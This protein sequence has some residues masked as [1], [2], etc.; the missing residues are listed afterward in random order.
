[1]NDPW[2]YVPISSGGGGNTISPPPNTVNPAKSCAASSFIIA[3]DRYRSRTQRMNLNRIEFE[4][5]RSGAHYEQPA[6]C[7]PMPNRVSYIGF[8][9]SINHWPEAKLHAG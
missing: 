3:F 4:L 6:A 1:M 9:M 5:A 7:Q 2:T 8:S